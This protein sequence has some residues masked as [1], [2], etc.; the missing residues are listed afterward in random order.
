VLP[1]NTEMTGQAGALNYKQLWRVEAMFRQGKAVLRTRPIYH[2]VDETIRGHVFCTF[3]AL[4]LMRELERALE[5]AA[6]E[7]E[8]KLGRQ[9]LEAL[10]RMQVQEGDK[11]FWIRSQ[12][13]GGASQ[14]FAAVGVAIPKVIEIGTEQIMKT[15]D[16]TDTG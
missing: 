10:Q 5:Q 15:K 6:V 11:T 16:A 4:V 8:W 7:W 2:K 12:L 9:D 13:Q 14:V 3:L 1:T